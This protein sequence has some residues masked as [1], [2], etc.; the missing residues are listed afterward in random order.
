[1]PRQC[2]PRRG[3]AR[4]RP[5]LARGGGQA[6]QGPARPRP[7]QHPAL[8]E[9]FGLTYL[10]VGRLGDA[11]PLLEEALRGRQAE[12]RPTPPDA[13]P[14]MSN[15]ARAYLAGKPFEAEPLLRACLAIQTK[16]APDEW[17]TFETRSL[18]GASLLGQ[19]KYAEAE[20]LLLQGYEGMK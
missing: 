1:Q 13:P 3:A 16:K 8:D 11:R 20:P 7:P 18:L 4:R 14:S 9:Q 5:G 12:P 17:R 19:K 2:L 6:V 15:L 10:A